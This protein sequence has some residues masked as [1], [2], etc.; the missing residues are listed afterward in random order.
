MLPWRL[1]V[2]GQ[3]SVLARSG[4]P[5]LST[6]RTYTDR[7][8]G[9]ALLFPAQGVQRPRAPEL[10]ALPASGWHAAWAPASRDSP[11]VVSRFAHL[12]EG[13]TS[14]PPKDRRDAPRVGRVGPEGGPRVCQQRLCQ[15]LCQRG[16]PWASSDTSQPL[17]SLPNPS[18][19]LGFQGTDP[20]EKGGETPGER[21]Q[22]ICVW[23]TLAGRVYGV[24]S[25]HS[26]GNSDPSD[27]QR[28][29][30]QERPGSGLRPAET[31]LLLCSAAPALP[32][33]ERC[34]CPRMR[35]GRLH[36]S[37]FMAPP[38]IVS[39]ANRKSQE[40]KGQ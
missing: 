8:L 16:S 32:A 27:G 11:R 31:A 1:H 39:Q 12:Q 37:V 25:P 9:P 38:G 34:R 30:P 5:P 36:K 17:E 19:L 15:P 6:K 20:G 7:A 22:L 40:E 14:N 24:C 28:L 13:L 10:S 29:P 3:L 33:R 23:G 35:E 2:C 4:G 26:W 21:T 18:L